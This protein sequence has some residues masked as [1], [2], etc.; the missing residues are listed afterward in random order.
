MANKHKGEISRVVGGKTLRMRLTFEQIVAIEDRMDRGIV[1]IA[2]DCT[3]LRTSDFVEI[4]A[5]GVEGAGQKIDR[6]WIQ[7]QVAE[8]GVRAISTPCADL[9]VMA[10]NGP[11]PTPPKKDKSSGEDPAPAE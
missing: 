7:E 5:L 3:R 11:Q 2:Y 6:Y 1:E 10:L 9:L 4:F 8:H